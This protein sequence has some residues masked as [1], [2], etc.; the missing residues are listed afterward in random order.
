MANLQEIT[1]SVP[2]VSCEH[3]VKT[4]NKALGEMSGVEGVQTDIRK[5]PQPS[6]ISN[7]YECRGLIHYTLV[8][9]YKRKQDVMN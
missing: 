8:R 9:P 2:D 1:L 7:K 4:V 3:C 5:T 6:L